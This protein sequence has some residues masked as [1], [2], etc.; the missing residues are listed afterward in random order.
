MHN[1]KSGRAARRVHAA[2]CVARRFVPRV[3][4]HFF[5]LVLLLFLVAGTAQL[6]ALETAELL[7]S[8]FVFG[9][10]TTAEIRATLEID[11]QGRVKERTLQIYVEQR[12][13][14]RKLYAQIVEPPFLDQMRFLST[15][16][17]RGNEARWTATSTGVRRVAESGTPE[18]LFGSDFTVQDLAGIEIDDYELTEMP[19]E[20]IAGTRMR[21]ISARA[22]GRRPQFTERRF[23]IDTGTDLV[24]QAEYLDSADRVVKRYRVHETL[25]RDGTTYPEV[26]SMTNLQRDSTSTLTITEFNL[27]DDIP[28]RYFSRAV[29]R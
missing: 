27:V 7:E 28:E 2:R 19:D 22:T 23:W 6:S 15:T 29:L 16:D 12:D 3:G 20:T 17:S 4:T 18:E 24:H 14:E 8:A 10:S 9:A 21:V 1:R 13:G 26:V 25:E 5:P 11:E